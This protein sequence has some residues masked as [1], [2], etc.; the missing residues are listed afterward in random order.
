M[1]VAPLAPSNSPST[2]PPPCTRIPYARDSG[3]CDANSLSP[4]GVSIGAHHHIYPD[5]KPL[6]E[7][8]ETPYEP[9]QSMY[10]REGTAF[11]NDISL[12]RLRLDKPS[13]HRLDGLP[14]LAADRSFG[15]PAGSFIA[16]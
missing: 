2:F 4:A 1:F 7:A 5:K 13:V 6:L 10:V 11:Q 12:P 16:S 3:P 14:K 15:S 8:G 9:G